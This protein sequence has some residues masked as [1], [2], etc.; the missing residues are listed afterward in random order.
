[1]AWRGDAEEYR[2]ERG[3]T[4]GEEGRDE[5]CDVVAT[6]EGGELAGASSQQATRASSSKA[7]KNGEAE[8]A[9][10]HE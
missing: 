2:T 5:K 7:G 6:V 9:T 3:C 4:G 1:M 8:C 10:H